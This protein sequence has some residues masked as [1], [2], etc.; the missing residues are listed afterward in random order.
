MILINYK[1]R[2]VSYTYV[3]EVSTVVVAVAG[4]GGWE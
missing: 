1:A 2:H 3:P 4:S